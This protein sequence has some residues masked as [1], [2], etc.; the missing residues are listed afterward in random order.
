MRPQPI[1]R[2][3]NCG[4]GDHYSDYICMCD[5]GLCVGHFSSQQGLF[6]LLDPELAQRLT[7]YSY[8]FG[9]LAKVFHFGLTNGRPQEEVT[10]SGN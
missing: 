8:I 7:F 1:V 2:I 6:F 9:F 4:K 3:G 10:G 5:T